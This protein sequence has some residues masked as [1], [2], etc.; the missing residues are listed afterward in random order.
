DILPLLKYDARAGT[1]YLDDRVQTSNG[2]EKEQTD[3]T[4]R[5][6]AV[7]DMANAQVGWI[8]FA[9]RGSPPET[10]L[11]P[12]GQDIGSPTSDDFKQGFRLLVKMDK[13]PGGEV[14]EFISTAAGAWNGLSALHDDY[15]AGLPEHRGQLPIVTASDIVERQYAAGP[16]FEPQFT[17]VGWAPRPEELSAAENE[18][19]GSQRRSR[20]DMDDEISF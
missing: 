1:F 15:L 6:R 13:S 17:I 9:G 20:T 4:T 16:S 12:V 7:V 14:R 10:I 19:V 18:P 2:W 11:V 8:K 3:V 5:F